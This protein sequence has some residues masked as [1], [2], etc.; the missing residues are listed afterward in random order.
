MRQGQIVQQ[1][2][3]REIFLKPATAFVADFMGRTNMI[4]GTLSDRSRPAHID[5]AIGPLLSDTAPDLPAGA[6]VFAVVRPQ[7]INVL[8]VQ[9]PAEGRANVFRGQLVAM[10]FVGDVI[11]ADV[12]IRDTTIRLLLNPY[13]ELQVGAELTFEIE[14]ARC[15]VVPADEQALP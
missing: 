3:P 10:V 11:E 5:T 2:A 7:G 15:V 1:G 12:R 4:P 14:A 6:R 13:T 9:P 8:P